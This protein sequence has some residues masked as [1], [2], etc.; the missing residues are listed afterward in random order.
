MMDTIVTNLWEGPYTIRSYF[1][2]DYKVT[3]QV[4]PQNDIFKKLF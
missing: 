1:L 4:N 3:Y 2:I